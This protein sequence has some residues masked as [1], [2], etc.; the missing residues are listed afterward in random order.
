MRLT[1]QHETVYNYPRPAM[2][3]V[4]EAWMRPLTD[5]RQTCL[6]FRLDTRPASTPRPYTDYFG[7]TVYHF[8]IQEQHSHLVVVA[9][10]EVLTEPIDVAAALINDSSNY[11]PL[12]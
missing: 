2:N 1:I 9:N 11:E 12:S 10:A 5:D 8:D 4:N 6:T 7:N 3:S